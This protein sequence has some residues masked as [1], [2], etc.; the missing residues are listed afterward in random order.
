LIFS[1]RTEQKEATVFQWQDGPRK[2]RR[3]Y[4]TR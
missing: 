2:L 1:G 3:R 4:I